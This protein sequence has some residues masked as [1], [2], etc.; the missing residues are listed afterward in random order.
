MNETIR[1]EKR[2]AATVEPE[3]DP[4]PSLTKRSDRSTAR[5]LTAANPALEDPS[6]SS[7]ATPSLHREERGNT[8]DS[9]R[10]LVEGV[11]AKS[12][13][14]CGGGSGNSTEP[15]TFVCLGTVRISSV[16]SPS[17]AQELTTF[18][19]S[20][21]IVDISCELEHGLDIQ[22][23]EVLH[24]ALLDS[25]HI[26]LELSTTGTP[27]RVSI[28][29]QESIATVNKRAAIAFEGLRACHTRF[30]AYTAWAGLRNA[31]SQAAFT[32]KRS[33]SVQINVNLYCDE[34]QISDV[35]S[36]L[37]QHDLFLQDPDWKEDWIPYSNPQMLTFAGLSE[38]QIMLKE[39]AIA[40]QR[41][42]S[43]NVDMDWSLALDS[44]PQYA[45]TAVLSDDARFTVPLQPY[46]R[47]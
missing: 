16:E 1:G 31:L 15:S 13:G 14:V 2:P 37:S 11:D 36:C 9:Q 25:K 46:T 41:T 32:K 23:S 35:A 34:E 3:L 47:Q 22:S 29:R 17:R 30:L 8:S 19:D 18:F 28:P 24:P 42:Q 43:S 45:E 20:K 7:V 5:E 44:L 6:R 21:K 26:R 12:T 40:S 38:T 33:T 27:C 4:S 10:Q 39:M